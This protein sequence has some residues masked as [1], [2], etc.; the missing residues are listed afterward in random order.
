MMR[1]MIQLIPIM[2]II[3][4][5]YNTMLFSNYVLLF[6][7]SFCM[8]CLSIL[9][10]FHFLIEG[11]W[12]KMVGGMGNIRCLY[13][14]RTNATEQSGSSR[15][16]TRRRRRRS[17]SRST[18]EREHEQE[19]SGSGSGRRSGWSSRRKRTRRRSSRRTKEEQGEDEEGQGED[20][21]E[22]EV[23]RGSASSGAEPCVWLRGPLT[24]LRWPIPPE[25]RSIIRS[26]RS[27]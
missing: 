18:L 10:G 16:R 7:I 27:R 22:E 6:C 20:E 21:D 14:R 25:R 9:I 23:A 8:S 17:R 19:R 3:S 1:L 4:N 26:T 12:T 15:T 5:T 24:L 13:Q 2:M 11:D